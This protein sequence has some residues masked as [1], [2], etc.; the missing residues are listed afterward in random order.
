MFSQM[1]RS[2]S[3]RGKEIL[4]ENKKNVGYQHFSIFSFSCNVFRSPLLQGLLKLG[5]LLKRVEGIDKRID[6]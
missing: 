6:L 2:L 5:V 4:R 3:K 1:A